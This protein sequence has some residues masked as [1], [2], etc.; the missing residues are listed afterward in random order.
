MNTKLPL[1][2]SHIFYFLFLFDFSTSNNAKQLL[3]VDGDILKNGRSYYILPAS[4]EFVGGLE[5][6]KV[7]SEICSLNVVQAHSEIQKGLPA[8]IW[9]PARIKIVRPSF[10]LNIPKKPYHACDPSLRLQWKVDKESQ[11]V[12]VSSIEEEH[13]WRSFSIRP[14]KDH[15]KLVYCE[16]SSQ[17][18]S[19]DEGCKDLGISTDDENNRC[20]VVKDG[21]PLIVRFVKVK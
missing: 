8:N 16:T 7:G 3:D 11:T 18:N 12:K 20:L 10:S 5:L 1:H 21:D 13:M 19:V 4:R 9:T 15:Y 2:Y 6:A 14:Y 17:A